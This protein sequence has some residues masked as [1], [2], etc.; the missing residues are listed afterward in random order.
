MQISLA[1]RQSDIP[2]KT[3]WK[4]K[5]PVYIKSTAERFNWPCEFFNRTFLNQNVLPK[6]EAI[7]ETRYNRS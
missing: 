2:T 6:S 4:V 7:H 3:L 1:K 5:T